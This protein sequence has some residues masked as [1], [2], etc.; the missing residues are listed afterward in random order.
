MFELKNKEGS[1]YHFTLKAKNGQVIL[2]SEVYNSKAAAENGIESVK[3]NAS[4]DG[5][6][7]RKTAKNGKFFFNLKAGNGQVI[8]SSQMYSSESGMENGINSVRENAP[9]AKTKEV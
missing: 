9:D 6:Y 5:R 7:E 1:S 4:E 8:G 3:K 2:S